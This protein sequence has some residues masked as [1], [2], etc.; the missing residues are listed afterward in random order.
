MTLIRRK[1]ATAAFLIGLTVGCAH[2]GLKLN[3]MDPTKV[4]K[5]VLFALPKTLLKVNITYS[6]E[7]TTRIENGVATVDN[8]VVRLLKPVMLTPI[9]VPDRDAIFSLSGE[10]VAQRALIQSK[11]SFQLDDKGLLQGVDTEMTEKSIEV[12]QGVVSAGINVA[13]LSAVAGKGSIEPISNAIDGVYKEIRETVAEH[14]VENASPPKPTG[15]DPYAVPSLPVPPASPS[16]DAKKGLEKSQPPKAKL[17]LDEK[18]K[19]LEGL[20]KELDLLHGITDEWSKYNKEQTEI[21]E[22]EY[23]IILEPELKA[24]NQDTWISESIQPTGLIEGAAPFPQVVV[25]VTVPKE[26]QGLNLSGMKWDESS[27]GVLYR[28]ATSCLTVITVGNVEVAHDYLSYS[29]FGP[30]AVVPVTDKVMATKKT[31]LA[32]GNTGGLREF[33]QESG[34]SADRL[35]QQLGS[36]VDSIQKAIGEV[37]YDLKIDELEKQKKLKEA[38]DNLKPKDAAQLELERLQREKDLTQAQIDLEK[39][40]KELDDLKKGATH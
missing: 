16:G 3:P 24:Q 14:T 9:Q 19:R 29:Q 7:K 8:P 21:K 17:T 15:K 4:N 10:G 11:L 32:F 13:K 6:V 35:V 30:V 25:K 36:S 5:G 38:E 23:S 31:K 37:R 39:A 34:S 27:Q 1:C 2:A 28:F 26:C 12:L 40:K 20:R 33:S 22:V 18:T